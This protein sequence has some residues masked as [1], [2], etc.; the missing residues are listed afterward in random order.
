MKEKLHYILLL[1][2]VLLVAGISLANMQSVNVS[3]ILFSFKLPLIILIL[4]AVLLGS[5]TTFLISMVKNFSLKKEL[6]KTKEALENSHTKNQVGIY[7]SLVFLYSF[8]IDI[9]QKSQSY[10]PQTNQKKE[11]GMDTRQK[12]HQKRRRRHEKNC[13]RVD[14]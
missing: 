8:L 11:K 12:S 6:K 13:Q 5:V 10:H 9:R 14:C 4:I 3:F 7:S 1:I 2:T